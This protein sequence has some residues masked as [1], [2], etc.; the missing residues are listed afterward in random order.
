M[1][2]A[3]A[4]FPDSAQVVIVGGGIA[5][6]SI[7]YHLAK[8]GIN[9][10]VLVE[11]GQLTC[12]TT[13]HAAGL[14]GQMRRTR[15]QTNIAKYTVDLFRSLEAETGQAT[16][17]RQTGSVSFATHEGRMQDYLRTAARAEYFDVELD[18]LDAKGVEARWP[19]LNIDDVV[20]GLWMPGDG[21]VNPVDVSQAMAKG[22]RANGARLIE[23]ITVESFIVEND[24]VVGIGT[25]HGKVKAETVILTGGIWTRD[26][27]AS[28]GVH[29]PLYA[30]EHYYIVTEPI[31]GLPRDLP[32][33]RA[34]DEYSYYKEDAGKLL[35][36]CFEPDA[37]IVDMETLPSDFSFDELPGDMEHFAPILERAFE[38]CHW[39]QT[40]G[41]QTFFC[42]PESFTPD[43]LYYLGP[44]PEVEGLMVA[45]GFNSVGIQSSAGVGKL[46]AEWVCDGK[47]PIDVTAYEMT[48]VMP[49]QATRKYLQVRIPE[50]LG[51]LFE[52]HYPYKQ[53][54]TARG[55]RRSPLHQLHVEANACFGHSMGWERPMW[56]APAGT[57]PGYTYRFGR[58][59]WFDYCK[60]ECHAAR[61]SVVLIDQSCFAKYMVEGADALKELERLCPAR[62]DT[63]IGKTVYTQML[64]PDGGIE[65]DITIT[66]ISEQKFFIVG[67]P[68]GQRRDIWWIKKNLRTGAHVVVSDVTSGTFMI[69]VTGP[70][71]R[72]LMQSVSS[73]DFSNEAFP[74]GTSR[75][76]ELGYAKVRATRLTYVGELGWEI[77]MGSEYAGHV[78]EVLFEAGR[79]LGLR[80]AGYHA[81]GTMRVEKAMRSWPHDIGPKENLIE[82]GLGFTVDWGKE[83]FI[84]REP[85]LDARAAGTPKSRL[86][87]IK[88]LDKEPLLFGEEPIY[89]NGV[90]VGSI[91]S[92]NYG[93]RIDASLGMGYLRHEAGVNRELLAN[94]RIEVNVAGRLVPAAAQLQAFYDPKRERVL[95]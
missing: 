37:R 6:I 85:T 69:S 26:L 2:E 14:V 75:D 64:N 63:E 42:G 17:F 93:H 47:P 54:K 27:A 36:G 30:A 57:E 20:S 8:L 90:P 33:I 55:V 76:I 51:H 95:T 41:I 58:Q 53:P 40:A 9:D 5:G 10:V 21:V 60:A 4:S 89:L 88:L 13:W 18:V 23:G 78:A 29:V 67:A 79:S 16:G 84:G 73:E 62:I 87:Q 61:D 91:T 72:A 7:A 56:Y 48:R 83:D 65:S 71:A 12:G 50:M 74:F 68:H 28:I 38:R 19:G 59:N 44:A 80:W 15:A 39:L 35:L 22:A 45:A 31:D 52:T 49:F 81:L 92:G 1:T 70:N 24:R 66:R 77:T 25:D 32:F 11:R 82:A 46:I 43:N 34:L 3:S 86:V 94:A